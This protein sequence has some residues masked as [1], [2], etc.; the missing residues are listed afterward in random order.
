[1]WCLGNEMDG[2]WQV[3]ASW[4]ADA[5]GKLA[6]RTAAAMT[7]GSSPDL[8]LVVVRLLRLAAMPTFGDWERTVLEPTAIAHVDYVSCHA[9]YQ[10]RDGDLGHLPRLGPSTLEL[11][12][13]TPW[14]AAADHVR[15]QAAGD[16]R[17]IAALPR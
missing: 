13:S 7:H 9:Y 5:Y 14:L 12:T 8:E 10:Q 6:A 15:P 3:R 4:T 16:S 11:A 2:P 17:T 1:M